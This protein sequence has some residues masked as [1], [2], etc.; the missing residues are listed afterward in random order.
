MAVKS[1][2][3]I[4][5]KPVYFG[6][7]D[8][9]CKSKMDPYMRTVFLIRIKPSTLMAQRKAYDVSGVKVVIKSLRH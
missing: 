4:F 7:L 6:H 9:E 2:K 1:I 3:I 5:P 8:G